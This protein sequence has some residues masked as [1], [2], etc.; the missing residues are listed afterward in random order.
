LQQTIKQQQ[1][2]LNCITKP[3][4]VG[5]DPL[6]LLTSNHNVPV[7]RKDE[8]NILKTDKANEVKFF[9]KPICVGTGPTKLL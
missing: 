1:N 6:K 2:A 3:I 4:S 8:V 7:E 9:I 5:I